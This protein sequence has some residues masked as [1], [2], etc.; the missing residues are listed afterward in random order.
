[1]NTVILGCGDVGRRIAVALLA[2]GQE[3]E[4]IWGLVYSEVSAALC[5]ELGIQNA[6]F[7]LDKP[8]L[9]LGLCDGAQVYY[10]VAPQTDGVVDRRSKMLLTHL[11]AANIK[12]EKVVIISTTGVYGDCAGQWVDEQSLTDPQTERGQRRLNLEQQWFAWSE[13]SRVPVVGLR[14]P[15]IYAASRLPIERIQKQTPVVAPQE[16]G[17]VNRIHADDLAMVCI[18]AMRIGGRGEIYNATDGTPG[19]ISEYLQAAAELLGLPALP[20]ISMAQAPQLLS[21][22]MLSY[23]RESRKISNQK[24]L[25]ELGVKLMYP[26]FREGIKH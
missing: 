14:V 21:A 5:R 24:M 3:K 4:A 23:L 2:S 13:R 7:D 11:E 26:D 8:G 18:A 20:E 12:P 17:F 25:R 19:K 9:E 22:G 6:C 15:G 10:T 1:M 16:C